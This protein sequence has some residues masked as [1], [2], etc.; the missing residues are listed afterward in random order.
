MSINLEVDLVT[1]LLYRRW[2]MGRQSQGYARW[3]C[4]SSLM[5]VGA[6]ANTTCLPQ[7]CQ[8]YHSE[9]IYIYLPFLLL[10]LVSPPPSARL[11]RALAPPPPRPVLLSLRAP[12]LSACSCRFLFSSLVCRHSLAQDQLLAQPSFCLKKQPKTISFLSLAVPLELLQI[13]AD[14][15][16]FLIGSGATGKAP[17]DPDINDGI[18]A[19]TRP[20]I[21]GNDAAIS[22][23]HPH[24]GRTAIGPDEVA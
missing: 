24:D 14:L 18:F 10:V 7:Y 21:G 16:P 1:V 5:A 15:L 9:F 8:Q 11:L 20:F 13:S 22:A 4:T 3:T 2:R 19:T 6:S 17:F 23:D 12:F